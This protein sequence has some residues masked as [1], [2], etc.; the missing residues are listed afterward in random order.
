MAFDCLFP[1]TKKLQRFA[2]CGIVPGLR[3]CDRLDPAQGLH[4]LERLSR[5]PMRRR[6]AAPGFWGVRLDFG[7]LTKRSDRFEVV[8]RLQSP[9]RLCQQRSLLHVE[10]GFLEAA[11]PFRNHTRDGKSIL[12]R[13]R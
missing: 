7:S 6:Q 3:G 12:R 1:A 2:E 10:E 9:L 4:A 8:P 11:E 13:D 5:E